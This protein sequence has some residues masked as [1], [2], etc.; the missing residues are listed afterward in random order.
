MLLKSKIIIT[1]IINQEPALTKERRSKNLTI[2]PTSGGIPADEN[3]INI[4]DT[5][6]DLFVKNRLDHAQIFFKL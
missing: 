2:K 5:A 6:N 4:K 3:K 1:A